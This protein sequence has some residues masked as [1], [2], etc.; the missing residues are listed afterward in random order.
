MDRRT[1]ALSLAAASLLPGCATAPRSRVFM[2][3]SHSHYAMELPGLGKPHDL[4]KEMKE[5]GTTLLAWAMVDDLLW[6][7][8]RPTGIYQ[9]KEPQPGELWRFFHASLAKHN[10]MLAKWGLQ[11][12][13]TPADVDW[14]L[15][16]EPRIVLAVES[17]NFLE[18]DA[19]R[20]AQAQA[21]G[22]RHLQLVH[23]IH[24]P[25][26]DHQTQ[27]PDHAG[28]TQ[29]GREVIVQCKR[30]GILVDLAHSSPAMVEGA[31]DAA[32]G[33]MIWSHSWIGRQAY[34]WDA[35]GYLARSLPLPLA[36]KIAGRGGVMGLWTVRVASDPLYT[37]R[38]VKSFADETMRM[39]DLVG[40]EHV[41]FGTDMEGAGP[42]PV[43]ADYADLRKV[44]DNLAQRGLADSVLQ[45]LCIGNYARALKH[46]MSEGKA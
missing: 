18:G 42:N 30:H 14:A 43:L 34:T 3:D 17:A 31:L 33:V 32:P 36:R 46:A 35:P 1:F 4:A 29:S 19:S 9:A 16:G 21:L 22:V 24:S 27:K 12:A 37:V 10:A 23:Y 13:L 28:L 15:A 2:G 26:G 38:D 44:A 39:C 40:P 8:V 6:L 25:L 41:C 45:G 20:V 11:K 5:S 7:G